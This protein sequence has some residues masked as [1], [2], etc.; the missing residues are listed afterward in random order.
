MDAPRS[1]GGSPV[2]A[3]SVPVRPSYP[4]CAGE[5][6]QACLSPRPWSRSQPGAGGL[7]Q[8]P[9]GTGHTV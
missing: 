3:G 8:Y 5:L 4:G 2:M 6:R 1:S 7:V 9:A